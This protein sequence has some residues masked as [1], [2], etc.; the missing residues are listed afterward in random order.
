MI[1]PFSTKTETM[2]KIEQE[3][4]EE[5]QEV[6]QKGV[7]LLFSVKRMFFSVPVNQVTT[8]IIT[9]HNRGTM[10]VHF[11]WEQIKKAN[12]LKVNLVKLR[13]HQ[14]TMECKDSISAIQRESFFQ[15]QPTIFP[16]YSSP[17]HT[18]YF[19]I[20]LD[21]YGAVEFCNITGVLR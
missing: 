15:V 4:E 18:E 7:H 19:Q 6:L 9:V 20:T 5:T 17:R 10:T 11:E 12:P 3:P 16:S 8:S 14:S 1:H 2:L 21:I 13:Y